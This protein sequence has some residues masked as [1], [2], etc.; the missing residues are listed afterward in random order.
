MRVLVAEDKPRLA[1]LLKRALVREGYEVALAMDGEQALN[2]GMMGGL[3]VLVLDVM[4]PYRDGFD[5]IRNLR[6][7]RQMTPALMVT[8]RDTMADIVRGLDLGADDYLTKP[9]SLEVLLARVRALSRRGPVTCPDDLRFKDLV[10]NRRTHELERGDR[11]VPLTR[12]EF[13]LVETLMRRSGNVVPRDV[14]A[15]AGWGSDVDVS[16]STIYVF[17]RSLRSKITQ[18][19][20]QQLLHTI[21]GVGYTLRAD[22][23]LS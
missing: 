10:L 2:M 15:E 8:A 14:L 6:A 5:V 18:P 7:A 19:G 4:L 1:N 16:D 3:D 9:F 17:M 12:T 13:E 22:A 23:S 21:R 20:E 11:R